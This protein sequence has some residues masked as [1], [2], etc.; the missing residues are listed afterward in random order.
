[1]D[2]PVGS[3]TSS[4]SKENMAGLALQRKGTKVRQLLFICLSENNK[5]LISLFF[6]A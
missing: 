4:E 5:K 2:F 3:P 1:M 6:T